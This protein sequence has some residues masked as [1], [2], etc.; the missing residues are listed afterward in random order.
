MY[1]NDKVLFVV[2]SNNECSAWGLSQGLQAVLF[3]VP[4]VY[5]YKYKEIKVDPKSLGKFVGQYG[6]IKMFVK[7]N[8]LYLNNTSGG[9]GEKK[10]IPESATKFYYANEND[11]QVEFVLDKDEMVTKTWIIAGG[12]KH[13]LNPKK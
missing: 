5:P 2:L 11:R 7:D 6:S 8:Y 9:E 12:I 1:F 10:L 13:E 3:N 4:I